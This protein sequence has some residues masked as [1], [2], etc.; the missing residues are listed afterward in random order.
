MEKCFLL[1]RRKGGKSTGKITEEKKV[2]LR[3]IILGGRGR[4]PFRIRS[5][6]E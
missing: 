1:I 2:S 6:R 3:P 5:I 4:V